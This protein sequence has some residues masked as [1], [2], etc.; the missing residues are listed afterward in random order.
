MARRM[1]VCPSCGRKT[2]SGHEECPHC[3]VALPLPAEGAKS[4]DGRLWRFRP[5]DLV[6][7][8]L[9]LACLLLMARSGRAIEPPPR[10]APVPVVADLAAD[11]AT[12]HP[13][14]EFE[15]AN[16]AEARRVA[17]QWFEAGAYT[18]ALESYKRVVAEDPRDAQAHNDLGQVLVRLDRHREALGYFKIA[19][20]LDAG[21]AVFHTNFADALTGLGWWDRAV[22]EYRDAAAIR[23]DDYETVYRLGVALHETGD[24]LGAVKTYPKAIEIGPPGAEAAAA[25]LAL[26]TSYQDLGRED[27]AAAAHAPYLEL[28]DEPEVAPVR[29]RL[30]GLSAAGVD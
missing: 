7:L 11:N 1:I 2:R 8:A 6:L 26:A 27:D 25:Y 3:E 28:A 22:M 24:D 9:G 13:Q 21:Q 19:V 17:A 29:A 16:V 20:R 30:S 15:G 23:P 14:A 10:P 5:T 4:P 18:S 12:V